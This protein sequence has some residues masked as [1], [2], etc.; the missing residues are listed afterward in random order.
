MSADN[1]KVRYQM[2][3]DFPSLFLYRAGLTT[4]SC[5]NNTRASGLR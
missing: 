4:S 1:V 2:I 5:M 3:L